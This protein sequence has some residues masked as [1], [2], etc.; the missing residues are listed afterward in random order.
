MDEL[1]SVDSF[2]EWVCGRFPGE[3]EYH[4]A[5]RSVAHNVFDIVRDDES[6][7]RERILQRMTEPD[8]SLSFRVCWEDDDGNVMINRGY[9]VQHSS[10]IGPYKG[11]LRFDPTVNRS[12][13][14]FLAFEQMFKNSLTGLDLGAGKGGA[15]FDPHGRSEREIMRFCQAYM[16]ELRRHIGPLTDVPAGDIGVGSREV[17]YLFG[18]FK[19][20]SNQ[21][22]SALTGKAIS[23]G[24]SILR[25]EAT[26]FG[27]VYFL[28]HLLSDIADGIED[29]RVTISGAG[30]VA[31]H[32]AMK[33]QQLG[34]K[35]LTLSNRSGYLVKQDGL[36]G[37]DIALIK[38]DYPASHDLGKMA[39]QVG[40][41]WHEDAK[42]WCEECDV[43]I[44]SA[45]QNEVDIDDAAL[46]V[47]NGC[48]FVIEA[49]NM[50]VTEDAAAK[51]DG[52][53]VVIAPGKAANAGG[54]AVSGFEIWQNRLGQ[55]WDEARLD[56]DLRDVMQRIYER[57]RDEGEVDGGGIDYRRGADRAGFRRVAE[58]MLMLGLM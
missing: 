41:A 5:V 23:V 26:G 28:C 44:P 3:I 19:R 13:L 6:L 40:A 43:A 50:P 49:A 30:N 47:D 51:L 57:C 32:A 58:A 8:R 29:K 55:S 18:Q 54:V 25:E 42:P 15:D 21:Y 20:L 46:L 17:G 7:R 4:Q 37:D 35:V 48:K 22:A 14:H 12:V 31:M 36:T 9:R 2:V 52:A 10:A 39:E 16:T 56:R 11:G 34:A 45:T 33:A 53:G 1:E 38:R 27:A 24:G